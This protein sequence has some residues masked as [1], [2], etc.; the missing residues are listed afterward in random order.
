[1][2]VEEFAI[3]CGFY[4]VFVTVLHFHVRV[5]CFYVSESKQLL[6]QDFGK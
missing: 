6:C 5:E 4:H 2:N 3:N 1:M